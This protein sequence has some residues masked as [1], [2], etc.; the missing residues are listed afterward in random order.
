MPWFDWA[1][2]GDAFAVGA[3]ARR[4]LAKPPR[5][6]RG[7]QGEGD[8]Q[9]AQQGETDRDRQ[10]VE[11]DAGETGDEDHGQE[12]GHGGQGAGSDRHR[13][14]VAAGNRGGGGPFAL[15]EPA[16]DALEHHDRTVDQHADS[17]R[18]AGQGDDVQGE[19]VEVHQSDRRQHRDRDGGG[20]DQGRSYVAEEE[21]EHQDRQRGAEH[22]PHLDVVHGLPDE[23]GAV[24]ED[25]D[26]GAA[27][28]VAIDRVDLLLQ[29]IDD[30]HRVRAGLLLH[31][32]PHAGLAVDQELVRQFANAVFDPPDV[33]HEDRPPVADRD[34]RVLDVDL[35]FELADR[36]DE[37]LAPRL[38]H[39]AGRDVAVLP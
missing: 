23:G 21:E 33:A 19:A 26:L 14:L 6:R 22:R 3:A 2:G 16:V 34:D 9:R 36:T 17:K 7:N 13:H 11:E 8:E 28:V 15:V 5:G 27:G 20:D 38:E 12:H 10:L 32:H 18:D 37:N 4:H 39:V 35:A 29:S 30:L 25:R 1:E 31:E 24:H